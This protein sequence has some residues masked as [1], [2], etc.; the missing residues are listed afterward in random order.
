[1]SQT[2]QI[3]NVC[4][5]MTR[6]LLDVF[7]TM[8][9]IKA[10]LQPAASLPHMSDRV[11]GCVGFAGESVT[12]AVYVHFPTPLANHVAGSMLGLPPAELGETEVN[13]VVGEASNMLTGGLKSWLCDSG[14][15]CAMSTPAIIRGS[16]FAIEPVPDV[17]REWLIF[18]CGIDK[19]IVEIHIKLD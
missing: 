14:A 19:V 18:D 3:P 12:G 11:T 8:L 2:V 15:E 10:T 4:E 5:F 16:S 17:Q 13:D 7:D 1:M 6:H 9:S